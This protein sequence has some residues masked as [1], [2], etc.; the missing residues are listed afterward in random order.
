MPDPKMGPEASVAQ[1]VSVQPQFDPM[2]GQPTQQ[3]DL[4]TGQPLQQAVP[5]G[6]PVATAVSNAGG[7]EP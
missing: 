7:G 3:F 6:S 5:M 2:T 4:M 1:P